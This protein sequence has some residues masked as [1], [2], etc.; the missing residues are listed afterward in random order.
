MGAIMKLPVIKAIATTF[1]FTLENWRALLLI[2][3]APYLLNFGITVAFQHYVHSSITG[4]MGGD[5]T[6][7]QMLD[8]NNR[9][10]ILNLCVNT[11]TGLLSLMLSAGILRLVIHAEKPR[12]I[13]F[14]WTTD[15]WLLLGTVIATFALG[16]AL[17][18]MGSIVMLVVSGVFGPNP[19]VILWVFPITVLLVFLM[20]TV[21][22]HLAFPAAI[23]RGEFGVGPAWRAS[24]G[25]FFRL[26]AYLLVWLILGMLWQIV[27]VALIA[28]DVLAA[29]YDAFTWAP[30][31]ITPFD[32]NLRILESVNATTP[33]GILRIAGLWVFNLA[34]VVMGSIAVGVAWRM[35]DVKPARSPGA[36]VEG[37]ASA[38]MGF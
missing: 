38:V 12:F 18:F 16:W 7:E 14:R 1:A 36:A 35:I 31:W 9:I 28:P 3:W 8:L 15:E 10:A 19:V 23:G 37:S 21:R 5:L 24:S 27:A 25:Q 13:Y 22:L 33:D 20:L 17:G 6:Y 26:L 32:L 11:A 29:I 34:A 4:F 2:V 30:Q